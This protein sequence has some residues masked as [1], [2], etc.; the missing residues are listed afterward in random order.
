MIGEGDFVRGVYPRQHTCLLGVVAELRRDGR[1]PY[2]TTA[3]VKPMRPGREHWWVDAA[4]LEVVPALA[5]ISPDRRAWL[6]WY[7]PHL[8]RYVG[9]SPWVV[10]ERVGLLAEDVEAILAAAPETAGVP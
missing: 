9:L 8:R 6:D 4:H 5:D 1:W 10:A 3:L 7:V 2:R